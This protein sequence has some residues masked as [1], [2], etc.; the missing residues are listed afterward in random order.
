VA[1]AGVILFDP[2]IEALGSAAP[3]QLI[4][5]HVLFNAALALVG[6]AFAGPI[7]T[8][9]SRIVGEGQVA[10]GAASSEQGLSALSESAL[11]KP[12]QALANATREVMRICETVEVMLK[13]V[14]E[15]YVDADADAMRALAALDDRVDSSHARIKLYLARMSA[16]PLSETEA[17]RCQELVGACVKLEQVGDIVVRNL[18]VHVRRKHDRGLDFTDEGWR[19]LSSFHAAVTSNARLAFNLLVT[20][21]AAIARQIVEEKDRLRDMEKRSSSSHFARLRDGTVKSMETSAIHLD[22][23][24][25]LK[26]IN[27]LLASIAYPILEERGLLR[28]SRLMT[29]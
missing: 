20:R 22:T 14:G 16:H 15:L 24:R 29:E 25:D 17:L 26:Q 11:D 10:P 5:A 7:H 19:E 9:A 1:L 2:S 21:D 13:R 23:I 28:E 27:S 12:A 18:L 3:E 4:H 6:L 8:L